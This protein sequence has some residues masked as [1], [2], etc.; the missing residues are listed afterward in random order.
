[1]RLMIC[2][3]LVVLL[4]VTFAAADR[5]RYTVR[6][7]TTAQAMMPSGIGDLFSRF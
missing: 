4:G 3:F 1:M 6:N 2:L 5:E 7:D